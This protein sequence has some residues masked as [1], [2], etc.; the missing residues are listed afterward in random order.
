MIG[1]A[2]P[3]RIWRGCGPPRWAKFIRIEMA[4]IAIWFLSQPSRCLYWRLN[5]PNPAR[6]VRT[7][8]GEPQGSLHLK[9][10]GANRTNTFVAR[11]L[12]ARARQLTPQAVEREGSLVR[13]AFK[14]R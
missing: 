4:A 6:T 11:S 12:S 2:P 9:A 10:P 3:T 14:G 1:Q 5:T 8:A 13:S 7:G